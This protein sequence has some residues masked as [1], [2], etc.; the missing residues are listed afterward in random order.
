MAG[1]VS[2]TQNDFEAV[3][4]SLSC[5]HFLDLFYFCPFPFYTLLDSRMDDSYMEC[6]P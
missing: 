1:G 4:I 3:Y 5:A 6:S 2:G